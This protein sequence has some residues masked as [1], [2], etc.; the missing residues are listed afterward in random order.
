MGLFGFGKK[1]Q[2]DAPCSVVVVAAGSSSR[3]G[4]DKILAPL[5]GEP[6]IIHTLRAFEQCP[7]VREIVLVT[8]E[9][10]LVE[11]AQLCRQYGLN[12]VSQ[13]I[14][15]GETRTDSVYLGVLEVD[16]AAE[17]IAVQDGARPLISCAV[18]ER[19]IAQAGK[20]GAAAPAIPVKDTVK[21]A[22][23]G[24]VEHTP[25]RDSLYAV[26]TPQVF[27]ASLL[28]GALHKAR[29]AGITGTD[30]CSMVERLGMKVVLVAGEERNIKLT[31]PMDLMLAECLLGEGVSK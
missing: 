3:M 28:K 13:V 24:I 26:Q 4:I 10:L 27:E 31:T 7:S 6:V 2:K 12:K 5:R 22:R 21:V 8:R 30:D 17:L 11:L 23:N 1:K 18:I 20:S 29:E 15:G 25:E 9:D 14:R 16:R 19:T